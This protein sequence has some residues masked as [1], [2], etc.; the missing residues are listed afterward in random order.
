MNKSEN[1]QELD[2]FEDVCKKA[3]IYYISDLQR[4]ETLVIHA[5]KSIDLSKYP[6]RQI[7]D[8]A[9]YIFKISGEQLLGLNIS[10]G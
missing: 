8:F 3:G 7:D 10:G 4:N 1:N 5:L 6:K 2:L 9:Y